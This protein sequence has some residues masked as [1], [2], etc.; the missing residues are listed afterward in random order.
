MKNQ[1]DTPKILILTPDLP[2]PIRAGGQM[3]MASIIEALSKF[4]RIHIP[5]VSYEDNAAA[6]EWIGK[7]GGT[8]KIHIRRKESFF[9][10]LK[11]LFDIIFF[12]NNL[13]YNNDEAVFLNSQLNEFNPDIVWLETPYLSRYALE[14]RKKIPVVV[15]YWG[16][17]EGSFLDFK[18]SSG[19]SKVK[20]W[21][22]WKAALNSERKNA[23]KFPYLVSVSSYSCNFLEKFAPQSKIICIPIGIVRSN[24][25]AQM[26]P[27]KPFSLIMSGDFS[28]MPN[29]DAA[30][31]FTKEIFPI[32]RKK[33]PQA[34]IVF[35]GRNPVERIK[36]LSNISGVEV[37]GYIPDIS[38][39]IGGASVYVLP[40]RMGSGFRT[41]LLDVFPLGK[42]IVLTSKST[43][44]ID[45]IHNEN[46]LIADTPE[47]FAMHCCYL[48]EN[49]AERKRL[50]EN[51]R[52]LAE[53]A[54]SQNHI[55]EL[56]KK[57]V[58]DILR[59]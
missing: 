29:I 52:K 50:G 15:D 58:S 56:L 1:I 24:L 39:A 54:Y 46:C 18:Y 49:E 28:F 12:R 36:E 25:Q 2:Y 48:L 13:I 7:L 32:V 20:K 53:Q 47:E 55:E 27:V 26:A 34:S 10:K 6:T 43:E 33:H 17:S 8:M 4:A 11:C 38:R 9:S 14:W 44:G 59:K 21:L 41:K 22:Y 42:A 23:G 35:A 45:L 51:A 31:Y 40:L 16:T 19:L 5:C 30:I 3:R 37:T 57:L